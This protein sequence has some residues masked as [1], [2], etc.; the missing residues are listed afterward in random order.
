MTKTNILLESGTNELEIV[1]F[2]LDEGRETGNYCGYYGINVA[3]VLE[4]IQMP[5]L[6]EMPEAAHPSVLGAFSLRN[7][8]IPLI[9][10]AKWLKKDRLQSEEPKVIVTEFNQ[11]KS[12]FLVSGVTRIHR[13]GWNKIEA[14]TGYVSSL[15]ANSITGVIKFPTRIV[16]ILDMEKICAE[17]NPDALP[18][19]EPA[20]DI[21]QEI[22]QKKIKVLVA[23]D[24]TMARK[25]ISGILEKAGFS[26]HAVENGEI[27]WQYLQKLS[28]EAQESSRPLE[29]FLDVVVSDIEMPAMD[30]H[31]L[32]KL[33]KEDS[34]LKTV[35]VVLCSSI[36]TETLHHKGIA[37]GADDQ[38]SKAE[39]NDL[40]TKVYALVNI[41]THN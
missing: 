37:V 25:M 40:V 10:L 36:I 38:V 34:F 4:I 8:I 9:D 24:S 6:T 33:I 30:G 1:E 18:V 27:A 16:F 19:Q 32:T 2:Y 28:R 31:S 3:K 13:I 20:D 22:I 14:P 26:V 17:L 15:T 23:D 12:A 29:N 5:A 39:L 21:K 7:E 35:P 11:T 41:E